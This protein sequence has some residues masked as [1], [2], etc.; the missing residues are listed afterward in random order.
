MVAGRT[1]LR[2]TRARIV[3]RLFSLPWLVSLVWV[4]HGLVSMPR[5][6]QEAEAY[7]ALRRNT[8]QPRGGVC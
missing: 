2:T 1:P 4:A 7:C 6:R 3:R 8:L 5:A